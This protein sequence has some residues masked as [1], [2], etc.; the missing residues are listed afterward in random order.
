MASGKTGPLVALSRLSLGRQAAF[1]LIF[2]TEGAQD[3]AYMIGVIFHAKGS[4]ELP[5]QHDD[6]SID[7]LVRWQLWALV[8]ES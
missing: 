4:G 6:M 5:C 3:P 7:R 1:P 8:E 2:P